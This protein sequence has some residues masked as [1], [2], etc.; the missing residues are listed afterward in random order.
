MFRFLVGFLLVCACS[1]S[2]NKRW[3][4]WKK[5]YTYGNFG[6][7][8]FCR[9]FCV[10]FCFKRI[11]I[12]L[13]TLTETTVYNSRGCMARPRTSKIPTSARPF[14]ATSFQLQGSEASQLVEKRYLSVPPFKATFDTSYAPD[15]NK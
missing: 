11:I 9:S 3:I 7:F 1:H 13:K 10:V 4:W 12:R 14:I 8:T 15:K 5:G 6:A 2:N